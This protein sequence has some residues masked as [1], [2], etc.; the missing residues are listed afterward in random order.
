MTLLSPWGLLALASIGVLVLFYL[1]RVRYR[2]HVVGSTYLWGQL[3]RDLAVH[4]P[5]QRPRFSVLLLIQALV[6]VALAVALARPAIVTGAAESIHAVIVLDATSS[7][8][9]TDVSPTRFDRARS[10]ARDA[11][12]DLPNGSSATIVLSAA[13]PDVLAAETTDRTRLLSAL[14]AAQVTDAAGDLTGAL[15]MAVALARGRVNGQVFVFSDGSFEPPSFDP[16]SVRVHFTA[17][18]EKGDHRA[19]VAI[20]ARPEP[21][22]RRRY[23]AFVRVQNYGEQATSAT[24]SLRADDT[25]FESQTLKL[26]PNGSAAAIFTDLPFEARVL[27]A[28]LLEPDILA[29]DQRAWMV[30]ERRRATQILL[31]TRGNF[32]LERVLSLIPNA[33]VFRVPQR[34]LGAIDDATYDVVVFDGSVPDV[35]P[36]RPM[37]IVNPG[38]T[39][40]LPVTALVRRPAALGWDS[41]DPLMRFVDLRDIRIA[42]LAKVTPPGWLRTVAEAGGEPVI[43]AGERDGRRIVI[44]PFDLQSSNLP[45]SASFPI[46]ISNVVG[47]LEPPR[48][49]DQPVT[50]AG[51]S[52]AFTPMNGADELSIESTNGQTRKVKLDGGPLAIDA[53]MQVGAYAVRQIALGRPLVTEPLAVNL[54]D[55]LESDLRPRTTALPSGNGDGQVG[56]RS[57]QDLWTLGILCAFAFVTL[58]WWWFHRRA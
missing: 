4:E 26:E 33:E 15:R 52:L 48:A 34:R 2:D 13:N 45:L 18:G 22:N 42:R 28:R 25:L 53:P 29:A 7:M 9:A 41:N 16:G 24:V 46:L 35:P 19:I 56:L 47:Y 8:A 31:V 49:L 3:V 58:E 40:L 57:S 1:L 17:V 55:A 37:L 44:M 27:E 51:S 32:F 5:W 23:Q 6:L 30:L 39:P 20:D 12:S 36:A 10:L 11:V 21:K 38:D 14:N 50:R 43:L 54:T